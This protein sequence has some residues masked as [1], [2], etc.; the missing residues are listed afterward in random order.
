[1]IPIFFLL[2]AGLMI[3]FNHDDATGTYIEPYFAIGIIQ[4]VAV[5]FYI[6][7]ASVILAYISLTQFTCSLVTTQSLGLL[8]SL[9][10]GG[11]SLDQ[12]RRPKKADG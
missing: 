5:A 2:N 6:V 9:E 4:V 8:S 11:M 12:I 1:M 3:R 7:A 10:P